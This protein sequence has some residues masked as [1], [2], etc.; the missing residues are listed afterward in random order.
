M[1]PKV[2]G[3]DHHRHDGEAVET[4]GDVHRIAG[5]DDHESAE[6]HDEEQPS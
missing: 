6:Q 5:A 3:G 4:V 1:K 2:R